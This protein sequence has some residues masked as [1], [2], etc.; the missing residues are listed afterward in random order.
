[1]LKRFNN[2]CTKVRC[3][4]E[5]FMLIYNSNNVSIILCEDYRKEDRYE[6][7]GCNAAGYRTAGNGFR[8]HRG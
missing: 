7:T 2:T 1:M 5:W 4:E 6:K 8:L 3:A